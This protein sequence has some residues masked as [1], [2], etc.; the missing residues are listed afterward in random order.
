MVWQAGTVPPPFIRTPPSI[1]F[2][3]LSGAVPTLQW[4]SR[5]WEVAHFT[6]QK[7]GVSGPLL[8][9]V[10]NGIG[11]SAGLRWSS[12]LGPLQIPIS[13][14][15]IPDANG[16]QSCLRTG[17]TDNCFYKLV[18]LALNI[19]I[20]PIAHTIFQFSK[21]NGVLCIQKHH[22]STY[23]SNIYAFLGIFVNTNFIATI[24]M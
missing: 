14:H 4:Y 22:H 23:T 19:H 18:H 17:F 2:N 20:R 12:E 21:E 13:S 6:I 10:L 24:C 9:P 11:N 3:G 5:F 8:R 1:H 15:K 7:D 16:P